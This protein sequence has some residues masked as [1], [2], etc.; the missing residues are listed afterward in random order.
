MGLSCDS[1]MGIRSA[2]AIVAAMIPTP[3]S[4]LAVIAV[5]IAAVVSGR[6]PLVSNP[7]PESGLVLAVVGGLLVGLLGAGRG[8][9]R[10]REGF[11]DDWRAGLL[12]ATL[13]AA[14]FGVSTLI[15]AAVSPSCS[16]NAG[17]V[18]MAIL[19]VPVLLLQA[20]VGPMV[21]RIMG[22]RGRAVA[23]FIG[24][25]LVAGASIA[26]D[27]LNEPGFRTASHFLVVVSGDLLGGASLPMAAI[28][29]RVATL[30]LAV[31]VTL[32]GAALWPTPKSR[33]LVSGATVDTVGMWIGAAIVAVLF[34]VAHGQARAALIPG[35]AALE[36][37]YSLVKRRGPLVVHA[38][39][40]TTSPREVDAML[41]EGTLWLDRLRQR[42]GTLSTD[43]IHIWA[44]QSRA[45]MARH[46]GAEHVDFALPWRREL[47][48]GSTVVPHPTL[49]HELAHVVLGERSDTFLRV[50]S[51]LIVLHNAALTEGMAMALTPELAVAE[52]LTLREQAAAMR[53]T[54]HAPALAS[55]FS[56]ARFFG[57]EPGRAYVTSGAFI[58][59]IVADAGDEAP[60]A[61]ERLYRGR[62]DLEAVSGDVDGLIARHER[63]LDAL[64]LPPDAVAFAAARFS[65]P[66]VLDEV[67]EPEV[68]E[69]GTAMRRL[70]RT[71]DL[72]GALDAGR[73]LEGEGADGT[74]SSLLSE[75][76]AVGDVEGSITLVRQLVALSPSPSERAV[77]ELALGVELWRAGREREALLVWDAIDERVVVV[78]LQR[79]ILAT[80][81]FAETALALRSEAPIARAA[82]SFF[83]ADGRVR[84]GARLA[85]ARA[86]GTGSRE[87]AAVIDLARYVLGRQLVQQGA[88]DDAIAILRPL[89]AGRT[90]AEVFHEQAVLGLATALVRQAAGPSTPPPPPTTLPITPP[91][92]PVGVVDGVVPAPAPAA[93]SPLAEA[94]ALLVSTAEAATRP[95]TRLFLRDR[96]ERVGRASSA[97]P[98]PPVSTAVT[99]PLWGDRLL[100]GATP[101]GPF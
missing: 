57:E 1:G 70:A 55:L 71:G 79:Q 68:Q 45:E 36:E 4:V 10:A 37:A 99:E 17:F 9:R 41:A 23:L 77:R 59:A 22:R 49:G 50:P 18:P 52:G 97:A 61:I 27:L 56:L 65:R 78:D 30:L 69:V 35:R 86:V 87:P 91:T 24:I 51:R 5:V 20:A 64:I 95:A 31:A 34:V 67:C 73:R 40:L 19:A 53:R 80:R 25:Q 100:L 21:G 84:E 3:G 72:P 42:L 8:A 44:H 82:L 66:S 2:L 7:G 43:D 16:T 76:R 11:L 94:Q 14:I 96:A 101:A 47:H 54:G 13:F 74:L 90:L 26:S 48:V 83:I 32:L 92:D 63:D 58:E 81:T 62:G 28:G 60:A 93:V 38:D 15:G 33:G 29:F 12:F 75:V 88:L 98:A 89:V 85:F 39:P 6:F 46:T